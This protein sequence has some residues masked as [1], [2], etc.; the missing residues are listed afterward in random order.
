MKVNLADGDV[1]LYAVKATVWLRWVVLLITVFLMAY[2]PGFWYP[3]MRELIFIQLQ[4]FIV[5]GA[6]HYL[7]LTGRPVTWRWMLVLSF[8]DIATITANVAVLGD[9]D[10]LAFVAYYPALIGFAVIFTSPWLGLAWATAVAVAYGAV[11]VG[12]GT[13]LGTLPKPKTRRSWPE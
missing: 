12:A 4:L 8:L 9:F 7:L 5:N 11:S 6:V 3:E 10:S 2:R 13:G 1:V